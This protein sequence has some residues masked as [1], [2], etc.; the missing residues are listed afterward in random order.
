MENA[1]LVIFD[2]DGVLVDVT[3]SYHRTILE[4]V[5]HFTGRR[6]SAAGIGRFKA[7]AG[8]ND[9]WKLTQTWIRELGGH[10]GA[11]EVIRHFQQ[12]YLGTNFRGY[13]RRER[14]L[15]DRRRLRRLA[16]KRELAIFT[17]RPRKEALFTLKR[18]GVEDCFRRIVAQEDVRRQKPHPEGLLR[19]AAGREP[20]EV[21]YAGDSADDAI[22]ARRAGVDFLAVLHKEAPRRS[23]RVREMRRLGAREVVES[24]NEIEGWLR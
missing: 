7:R 19:L 15:A 9:D 23:L 4:T 2:M 11:R 20:A 18:F 8:F 22:A 5:R 17:G 24:V 13:I 12:L 1:P 6:V 16:R 10:A 3:A 14:W 21:L